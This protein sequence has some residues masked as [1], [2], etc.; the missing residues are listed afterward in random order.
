MAGSDVDLGRS[1]R[2]DAEDQGWSSTSRVLSGRTIGW[3][4]DAVCGLYH[5]YGDEERMFLG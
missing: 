3:S 5:A 2:P 1:M 4:G